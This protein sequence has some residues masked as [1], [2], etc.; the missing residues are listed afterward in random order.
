MNQPVEAGTT[1]E[2]LKCH[3]SQKSF[4]IVYFVFFEIDVN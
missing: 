1:V 2:K 3:K 4:K